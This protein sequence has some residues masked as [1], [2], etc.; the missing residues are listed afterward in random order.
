M[1][2]II[3]F[4]L[5]LG[6]S[7]L[8]SGAFAAGQFVVHTAELKG[9]N[10]TIHWSYI[11]GAGKKIAQHKEI[12][13]RLDGESDNEFEIR[14]LDTEKAYVAKLKAAWQAAVKDKKTV[15]KNALDAA[16]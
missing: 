15:L 9:D 13:E 2:K 8:T 11:T 3:T 6:I 1:K 4:I 7:I 10:F 14:V 5:A 12:Y 16:L